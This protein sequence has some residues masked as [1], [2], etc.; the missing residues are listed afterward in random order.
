MIEIPEWSNAVKAVENGTAS[1]LDFF[2]YQNEPA[3]NPQDIE[4]RNQLQALLEY[5]SGL[6]PRAPDVRQAG[7]IIGRLPV[8]AAGNA[9]RWLALGNE[10]CLMENIGIIFVF[11]WFFL[12]GALFGGWLKEKQINKKILSKEN[13]I[14]C[15]KDVDWERQ[16]FISGGITMKTPDGCE[17][18]YKV[19]SIDSAMANLSKLLAQSPASKAWKWGG[20]I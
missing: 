1:P 5:V 7:V 15:F 10:R 19:H 8:P 2:V 6:T 11:C 17:H 14:T 18:F 3:G 4:F 9:N 20:G 13:V 12:L 16:V